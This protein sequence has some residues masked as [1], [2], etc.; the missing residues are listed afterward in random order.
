MGQIHPEKLEGKSLAGIQSYIKLALSARG[1]DDETVAQKFMLLMEET[2][3]LAQAAR[4]HARV[5]VADDST[6]KHKENLS[7]E[8]GDVLILVLDICNKLGINAETAIIQ[9]EIKNSKR[10]WQ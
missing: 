6:A 9:K 4:K 2:G 1:F 3:E 10:N 7:D 8:V 5:K